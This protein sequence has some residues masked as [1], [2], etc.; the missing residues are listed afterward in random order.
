MI[1]ESKILV[2]TNDRYVAHKIVEARAPACRWGFSEDGIATVRSAVQIDDTWQLVELPPAETVI[3]FT[4]IAHVRHGKKRVSNLDYVANL[5][6][7]DRQSENMGLYCHG[8]DFDPMQTVILKDRPFPLCVSHF[9]GIAAIK[10]V[11]AFEAAL[12]SNVGN[13]KAYGFG[14]LIYNLLEG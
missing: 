4:L 1:Y 2:P 7:L 10:N 12:I 8:M 14:F 13:A 6:W 5:N 9:R 3:R 11:T